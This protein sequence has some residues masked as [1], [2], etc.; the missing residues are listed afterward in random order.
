MTYFQVKNGTRT[1]LMID[2]TCQLVWFAILCLLTVMLCYYMPTNHL[3]IL[4]KPSFKKIVQKDFFRTSRI[5]Q[6]TYYQI[7]SHMRCQQKIVQKNTSRN[8]E[9]KNMGEVNYQTFLTTKI[10]IKAKPPEKTYM[11]VFIRGSL[12]R[13]LGNRPVQSVTAWAE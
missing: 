10:N 8:D 11:S 13:L 5:S 6:Q 3:K 9:Q 12:D 1:F 7:K 4:C 2:C